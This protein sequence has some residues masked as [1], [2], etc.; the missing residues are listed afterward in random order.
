MELV[1]GWN[2]N[3]IRVAELVTGWNGNPIRVVELV[4]GFIR[5][6]C[7]FQGL[8][9]SSYWGEKNIFVYAFHSLGSV[10]NIQGLGLSAFTQSV[11]TIQGLGLSSIYR[12][13][14]SALFI[15]MECLH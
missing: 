10:C 4:T 12:E 13:K 15:D 7:A 5:S 14:L 9:V 2:G 11:F 6:V 8:R 1:T 3:P